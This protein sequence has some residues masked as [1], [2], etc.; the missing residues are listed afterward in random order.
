M[1]NLKF[2]DVIDVVEPALD[3][4]KSASHWL[5]LED[6]GLANLARKYL[7]ASA[8]VFELCARALRI[9]AAEHNVQPSEAGGESSLAKCTTEKLCPV[10]NRWH[11]PASRPGG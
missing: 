4:I 10:H 2:E 7:V 8:E 3:Q 5:T 11:P 6:D 1:T 9:R